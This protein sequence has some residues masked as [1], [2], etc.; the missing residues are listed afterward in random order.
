[1]EPYYI[2]FTVP[3]KCCVPFSSHVYPASRCQ[4]Q[5]LVVIDSQSKVFL[6]NLFEH[7]MR[8]LCPIEEIVQMDQ[9]SSRLTRCHRHPTHGVGGLLSLVSVR[10]S[11]F[12]FQINLFIPPERQVASRI[13]A[14]LALGTVASSDSTH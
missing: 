1:M 4:G 2:R 6:C 3:K 12:I 8:P 11:E 9:I 7:V 5:T 14:Q 10:V 13:T